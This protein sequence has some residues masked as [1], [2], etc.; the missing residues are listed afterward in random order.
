MNLFDK[1]ENQLFLVED[2]LYVLIFQPKQ[3][4]DVNVNINIDNWK[5]SH[6]WH[7]IINPLH[8]KFNIVFSNSNKSPSTVKRYIL[9]ELVWNSSKGN[10]DVIWIIIF[11]QGNILFLN[12]KLK[13][14]K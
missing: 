11:E 9:N 13:I 6:T 12:N 2:Y 7:W 10:V 1:Q 4:I 3:E 8:D 14:T 5:I